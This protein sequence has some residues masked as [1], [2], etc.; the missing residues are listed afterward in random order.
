LIIEHKFVLVKQGRQCLMMLRMPGPDK[1][2]ADLT[3]VMARLG[4]AD[5]ETLDSG[6]G[7]DQPPLRGNFS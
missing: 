2:K 5:L 3:P 7:S 6:P 1:P 4:P